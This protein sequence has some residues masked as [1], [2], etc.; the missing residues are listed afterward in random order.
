MRKS[1]GKKQKT[2]KFSQSPIAS[3]WKEIG[4]EFCVFPF[5]WE[6]KKRAKSR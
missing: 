1:L 5:K 3:I 2:K 6:S 4:Q